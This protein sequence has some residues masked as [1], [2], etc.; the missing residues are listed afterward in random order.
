MAGQGQATLRA[1]APATSIRD[2]VQGPGDV[3]AHSSPLDALLNNMR[4]CC[5]LLAQVLVR[6]EP[7]HSQTL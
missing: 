4:V 5:R 6:Q 7:A 1:K 2:A 3:A